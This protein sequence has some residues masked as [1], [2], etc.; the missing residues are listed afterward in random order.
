MLNTLLFTIIV[1]L[2][3][4]FIKM[5]FI[6]LIMCIDEYPKDEEKLKDFINQNLILY[7]PVF[8]I[9]N[10]VLLAK[11]SKLVY[12]VITKYRKWKQKETTN[13]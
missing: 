9:R 12:L 11:Y 5:V 13:G 2:V 10:E 1:L 8:L 3:T 6:P 7:G 4:V